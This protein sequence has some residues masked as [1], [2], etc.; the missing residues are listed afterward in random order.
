MLRHEGPRFRRRTEEHLRDLDP[1]ATI[2]ARKEG[3]CGSEEGQQWYPAR[4]SVPPPTAFR[5]RAHRTPSPDA[6]LTER[7]K[8]PFTHPDHLSP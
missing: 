7:G 4:S 8:K 6:G 5:H 2:R 3:F 1:V